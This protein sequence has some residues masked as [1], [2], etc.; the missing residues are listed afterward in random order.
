MQLGMAEGTVVT[1]STAVDDGVIR[2][3][4]GLTLRTYAIP[5]GAA[6][7]YYPELNPLIPLW[8]HAKESKVPA[9]KSIPIRLSIEPISDR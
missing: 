8:H 9:A 4:R 5:R 2:Q 3:V 7:G 1:A 6:G